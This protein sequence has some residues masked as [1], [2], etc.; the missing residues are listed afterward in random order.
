MDSFIC[1]HLNGFKHRYETLTILFRYTVKDFQVLL[2]NTNNSIQ[3]YSFISPQLNS[4]K[5]C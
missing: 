3:N 5:Y 4:S 1:A 2:I